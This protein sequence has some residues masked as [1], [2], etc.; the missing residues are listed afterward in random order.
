MLPINPSAPSTF[1]EP[2]SAS[3][4]SRSNQRQENNAML[5]QRVTGSECISPK[6]SR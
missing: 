4:L 1:F 6:V 3:S 2:G 5:T